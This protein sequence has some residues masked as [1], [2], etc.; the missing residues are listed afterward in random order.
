MRG[1]G[2]LARMHVAVIHHIRQIPLKTYPRILRMPHNV[3]RHPAGG[4][5]A[6]ASLEAREDTASAVGAHAGPGGGVHLG[7]ERVRNLSPKQLGFSGDQ[8]KHRK[9]RRG[10][11]VCRP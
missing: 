6:E 1:D 9:R 7:P 4:A 3:F 2:G 11:V 8:D 5:S 10:A